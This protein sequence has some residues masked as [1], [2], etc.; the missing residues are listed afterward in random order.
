MRNT[1]R[2]SMRNT[3]SAKSRKEF[4]NF[5]DSTLIAFQVS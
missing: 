2:I 5:Q 1:M 3:T 4:V